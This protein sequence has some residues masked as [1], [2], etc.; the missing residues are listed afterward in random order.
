MKRTVPAALQAHL[1]TGATTVC[2]LIKITP[3]RPIGD[4]DGVIG[5]T[6]LDRYVDFD[7]GD[8]EIRYHAAVGVDLTNEKSTADMA[9]DNAEGSSLVQAPAFNLP[10]TEANLLAGAYDYS[11]WVAYLINYEDHTNGKTELKRGTL[12]QVRVMDSGLR[13][14]FEALGLTYALRQS[15][16]QRDSLACRATFGSG[17]P[18]DS[19]A[20]VI[21]RQPCGKD[22]S[23]MWVAF[24]VTAVDADEPEFAFDTDLAA[25]DHT[26]RPGLVRWT[27]GANTGRRY[28]VESHEGGIVRT[29][30]PMTFAAQVGDEGEIRADCTHWKEGDN[31]CKFHHGSEWINHYRGEPWIPVGEQD[32]INIPGANS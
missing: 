11:D 25:P 32:Q 2:V 17:P 16:V 7:D 12:G 10:V 13:F 30:F 1:D 3:R 27:T 19:N 22:T 28:E 14:V 20:E 29:T 9:V 6:T 24:E 15:I 23:A 31:G 8:G 26:Y 21:E 5:V 4:E 18:G